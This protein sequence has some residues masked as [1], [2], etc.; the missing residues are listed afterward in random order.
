VDDGDGTMKKLASSIGLATAA[1]AMLLGSATQ[2]NAK[3]TYST[4]YCG[5]FSTTYSW[6]AEDITKNEFK[7][8]RALYK[9]NW[10]KFK[11]VYAKHEMRRDFDE[12]WRTLA[13]HY[14]QSLELN[15]T[16]KRALGSFLGKT[17]GKCQ[18]AFGVYKKM[19]TAGAGE[20]IPPKISG[21]YE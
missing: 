12:D 17:V 1:A 2:A 8:I 3:I 16:D 18:T 15:K 10:N 7:I 11:A 9:K 6:Y 5:A 20:V 19:E 14:H 13:L 4:V 21:V